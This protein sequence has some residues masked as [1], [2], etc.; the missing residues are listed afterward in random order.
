MKLD[1]PDDRSVAAGEYVLGTLSD[2]ERREVEQALAPDA[3]LQAEVYAWQ[4]RLLPLAVRVAPAAAAR[5]V[6]AQLESRLGP[7]GAAATAPR[8]RRTRP[9]TT[10]CGADCAAGRSPVSPASQRR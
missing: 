1:T 5:A 4:D 8:P 2:A 3:A 6:W 9:A 10:R 7:Q